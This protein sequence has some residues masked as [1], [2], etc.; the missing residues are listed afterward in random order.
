MMVGPEG[1][2]T[3]LEAWPRRRSQSTGAQP[4]YGITI[5]AARH[6]GRLLHRGGVFRLMK[7]RE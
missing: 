1:R 6:S 7:E 2:V 3:L 5:F 4:G